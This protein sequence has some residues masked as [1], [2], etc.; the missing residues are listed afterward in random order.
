LDGFFWKVVVGW[1][2]LHNEEFRN[3]YTLPDIIRE[4]KSKRMRWVGHIARIGEMHSKC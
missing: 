1:R 3:L 4:I 2:S